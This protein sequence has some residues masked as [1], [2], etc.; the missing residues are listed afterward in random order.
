MSVKLLFFAH[1][2]EVVGC[3][4]LEVELLGDTPKELVQNLSSQLSEQTL[5]AVLAPS[6]MVAVN[7]QQVDWNI[8]LKDGDE[9]AFLPPFSGG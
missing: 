6:V 1:L 3:D 4:E 9:I 2:S 8:A 7:Q 5:S